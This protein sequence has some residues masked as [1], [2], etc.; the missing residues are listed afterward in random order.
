M[1]LKVGDGGLDLLPADNI[2]IP[3]RIVDFVLR[4]QQINGQRM[5]VFGSQFGIN[6]LTN[7]RTEIAIDGTFE[8]SKLIIG[9]FLC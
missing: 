7:Y 1:N 5:I 3:A 6:A 9:T 4:D 8:V 2:V